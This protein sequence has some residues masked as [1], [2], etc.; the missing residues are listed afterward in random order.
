RKACDRALKNDPLKTGRPNRLCRLASTVALAFVFGAAPPTWA[1]EVLAIQPL[2]R[3]DVSDLQAQL[4][5]D[6][7][8]LIEPAAIERFLT[9]MDGVPPDW[10]KVYGG[11]HHD[12]E[13]D[14]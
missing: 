3:L 11:G 14:E 4:P 6:T 1:E 8:L 7:H 13:L 2:L 5:A 10:T 12:P 9:F